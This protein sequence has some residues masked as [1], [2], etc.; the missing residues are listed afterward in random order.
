MTEKK[1]SS[2]LADERIGRLLLRLSV[3][4][5]IGMI[6]TAL[7]NVVDTIFVGRGVG[8]LGIA[9]VAIVFPIQMLAMSL[10]QLVGI[11]GASI[12]SRALGANDPRRAARTM[13]TMVL[14][15]ILI[16]IVIVVL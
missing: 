14:S 15:S 10:A 16:G 11:G 4:A 5:T 9:G 1:N 3:P 12:V 2:I 6:V 13:G 7:F 8:P